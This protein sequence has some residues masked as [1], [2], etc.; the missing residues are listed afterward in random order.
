MANERITE[1]IVRGHFQNDPLFNTIKLEEQK[2]NNQHIHNLLKNASKS[3]KGHGFP[4]FIISFPTGNMNYILVVECKPERKQHE[5]KNRNRPKDFA[6]DGVLHYA[7]FLSKEFDVVAI[8]ISGDESNLSVSNFLCRKN[9]ELEELNNKELLSIHDYSKIFDNERF[10]DNL[11]NVDIIQK[12]IKLNKDYQEYSITEFHRCTMVSAILVGLKD[13]AFRKSYGEQKKIKQLAKFLLGAIERVLENANIRNKQAM[14][15]E[16]GTIFNQPLFSQDNFKNRHSIEVAKEIIKFLH[17]SV[18][19]LVEMEDEG[20]DVL[21]RFYSE[22]VR[23]A[24]NQ[25]NQGVVLTPF[26]ITDLFCE[27][28]DINTES[29]VYDPCC[30]TGSFLISAMKSMLN[31]ASA[32]NKKRE[33]IK[34]EQLVGVEQRPEMATYACSNMMMRGD[35][36]S[37]IYLGDCF[38]KSLGIRDNH[39]PNIA[40]LN[41][42]Y[43]IDNAGQM[44]FIEHALDI[45]SPQSGMVAAI[46]QMSCTINRKGEILPI[47]KYILE[48]HHL[49]AVFSMPNELFDPVSGVVTAVMVFQAN[50]PNKGNKTWFGYFKD[51]GFEK[52]KDKGRTDIKNQW[53]EIKEKWLSS[54]R[55]MDEV[56]GLSIK[57]EVAY[58]DEWCVE[59]YMETDYSQITKEDFEKSLRNYVAFQFLN[60]DKL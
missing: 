18:Y 17:D 57:K 34:N 24:G 21:G 47:K 58:D 60:E 9:K 7:K 39:K 10:A 41:P 59:A 25:K 30:G 6:V 51:D 29:I 45:V 23:Y 11:L 19:P 55:N 8:A 12:A 46:V 54:Y 5:S 53:N 33:N 38:D 20:F 56:A 37:N 50:K 2:S 27:L 4:E 44:R 3:G 40:F 52:R 49:K 43:D 35:G 15:N 42:P 13:E 36:K 48:K 1:S 14:L 28:V 16:Y 32:N 26:H 31:L 22:F